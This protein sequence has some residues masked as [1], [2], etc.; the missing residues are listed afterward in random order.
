MI[1]INIIIIIFK[2]NCI[3]IYLFYLSFASGQEKEQ[4]DT[5]AK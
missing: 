1:E 2:I 5:M 4:G 3:M